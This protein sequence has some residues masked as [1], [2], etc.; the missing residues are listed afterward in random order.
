MHDHGRTIY[1]AQLKERIAALRDHQQRVLGSK[2]RL[3]YCR[4]QATTG[5]P[6]GEASNSTA[7]IM[8]RYEGWTCDPGR[9]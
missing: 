6:W 2:P 4:H 3:R 5:E 8:S 1:I 7:T 9:P